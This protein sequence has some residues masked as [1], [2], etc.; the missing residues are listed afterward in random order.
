MTDDNDVLLVRREVLRQVFD[1]LEWVAQY[2]EVPSLKELRTILANPPS[3]PVAWHLENEDEY[4]SE[5]LRKEHER[6]NSY[7][8]KLCEVAIPLYRKDA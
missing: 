2:R 5:K 8:F 7:T 6:V 3:E 1:E 4:M